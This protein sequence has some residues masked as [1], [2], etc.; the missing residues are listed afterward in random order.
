MLGASS[1]WTE[2]HSTCLQKTIEQHG[3]FKVKFNLH[4]ILLPEEQKQHQDIISKRSHQGVKVRL[5]IFVTT[6]LQRQYCL[7]NIRWTCLYTV[8]C[9]SFYPSGLYPALYEISFG[10]WTSKL[11]IVSMTKPPWIQNSLQLRFSGKQE[12][13]AALYVPGSVLGLRKEERWK[14]YVR[15]DMRLSD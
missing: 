13:I 1:E 8:V 3:C 4:N 11:L 10:F 14:Q 6:T 9:A 15:R 7:G 2:M 12:V 5:D